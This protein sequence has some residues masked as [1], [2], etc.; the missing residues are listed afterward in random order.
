MIYLENVETTHTSTLQSEA[1][2]ILQ[3]NDEMAKK[4]IHDKI[5]KMLMYIYIYPDRATGVVL[6][7][8]NP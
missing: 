5:Q 1:E 3:I 4:S 7:F 2:N 6:Q 8:L